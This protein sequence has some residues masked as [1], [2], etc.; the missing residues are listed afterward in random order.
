M[1]RINPSVA[2][3]DPLAIRESLRRLGKTPLLHV[4]IED[5]NF[6]FNITFG[7]RAVR[8]LARLA[9]APLDAHLLVT[10][11]GAYLADLAACGMAAAA[12]HYEAADY[13]LD[14]LGTIRK[15]GMRAGL[16][17]NFKTPAEA[18]EPFAPALDYVII[19]T[20]EPDAGGMRF[21]P[22]MLEKIARAR[23]ILPERVEVWADG[24]IGEA[25]TPLV[26]EAGADTAVVGRAVWEAADPA[27]ACRALAGGAGEK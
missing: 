20:A 6:V 19:M 7:L 9:P 26:A 11:P 1:I 4:D 23:T 17:L 22:P 8:E 13:P 5:G 10:N 27:A 24:G 18:L 14:L 25:E 2:S 16:A 15:A 21:H 3:A 12:V